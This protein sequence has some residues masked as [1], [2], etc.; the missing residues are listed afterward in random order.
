MRVRDLITELEKSNQNDDVM[1][2]CYKEMRY[3]FNPVDV[4]NGVFFECMPE[5]VFPSYEYA[6]S[7]FPQ[8]KSRLYKPVVLLAT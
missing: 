7:K 1:T 4:Y 5:Y 8:L 6:I 3:K 2:F